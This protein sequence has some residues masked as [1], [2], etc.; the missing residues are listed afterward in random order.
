MPVHRCS[1]FAGQNNGGVKLQPRTARAWRIVYYS[2]P[3]H[4]CA[5][6]LLQSAIV[7]TAVVLLRLRCSELAV[8]GRG[9][10][11]ATYAVDCFRRRSVHTTSSRYSTSMCRYVQH[12]LNEFG[13][14]IV[15]CRTPSDRT[16]TS[17]ATATPR[18]WR[19]FEA[20]NVEAA[21]TYFIICCLVHRHLKALMW[22]LWGYV[23]CPFVG[24]GS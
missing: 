4:L 15:S 9:F 5:D 2:T 23:G 6:L 14:G 22:W 10:W 21:R 3:L 8:H 17:V 11:R 7:W 12:E 13:Q 19:I 16:G 20:W 1:Q 18:T 24:W